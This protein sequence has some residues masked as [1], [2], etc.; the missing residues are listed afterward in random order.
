ME[1]RLSSFCNRVRK[2]FKRRTGDRRSSNLEPVQ[3]LPHGNPSI[4][5]MITP[6]VRIKETREYQREE[7]RLRAREILLMMEDME[8]NPKVTGYSPRPGRRPQINRYG[9]LRIL[10]GISAELGELPQV[11]F[12]KLEQ[13][14]ILTAQEIKNLKDIMPTA[15]L[16]LESTIR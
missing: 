8:T 5:I 4:P 11:D 3:E 10:M 15:A 16:M 14:N 2:T 13:E 6:V 12:K 9:M 7:T 1:S